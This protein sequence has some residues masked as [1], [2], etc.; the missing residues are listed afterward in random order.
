MYIIPELLETIQWEPTSFCNANCLACPRTDKETLLTL[1]SIVHTQRHASEPE[2]QSFI[3]SV[4]DPRLKK[5]KDVT[6]NGNIGDAM[7]HPQIDKILID[8]N[9]ARPE[10]CQ[11]LHTNGG[12]PWAEKFERIGQHIS[13]QE[14]DTNILF[15]FSVDGLEDTNHL[16]R[17]NVQW[18]HIVK[19]AEILRK[20]N[21]DV[22]WRWNTF[23]HNEHQIDEARQMAEDWGWNFSINDGTW[24]REE[25]KEFIHKEKDTKRF[26]EKIAN[27][28]IDFTDDDYIIPNHFPN[29][30]KQYN[31]MC[32]WAVNKE[33]QIVSDMSVWPCCWTSHFHYSYWLQNKD[34]WNNKSVN[35]DN[36]YTGWKHLR[37]I[38]QWEQLMNHD[39]EN[40]ENFLE[41]D[42]IK[43]HQGN[44]LYDILKGKTFN[45]IDKNLK[46]SKNK[47]NLDICIEACRHFGNRSDPDKIPTDHR[48]AMERVKAESNKSQ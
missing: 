4:V 9:R 35:L 47:F 38:K 7:M 26:K 34:V 43:I 33:I 28:E 45:H 10:V 41:L 25:I 37:Q 5:L 17:R 29:D 6:Y 32:V 21:A 12:G 8:I 48:E 40:A 16:Y 39:P 23:D 36:D 44:L 22:T 24:D 11:T 31:D 27:R 14:G 15:V 1:P 3:D 18:K 13:D 20:H 2:I 42:D 46:T 19:N 30:T